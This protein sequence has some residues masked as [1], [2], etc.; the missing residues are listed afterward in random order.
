MERR[1]RDSNPEVLADAGFRDRCIAVLPP[2]RG[3]LLFSGRITRWEAESTARSG[4][5]LPNLGGYGRGGIR[6]RAAW[7]AR[8]LCGNSAKAP[9]RIPPADSFMPTNGRGGI[10]THVTLVMSTHF[11]GVRLQPLGHP[12]RISGGAGIRSRAAWAA[13][14]L[15][16]NA[17]KA[18]GENPSFHHALSVFSGG[19]GIRRRAASAARPFCS[20]AAKVPVRIPSSTFQSALSGGAGIRTL[21]GLLDP[22]P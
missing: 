13:R 5:L 2:L 7:A 16:G 8:A 22:T 10:R 17:A 20:P 12:S 6:S 14:A 11:P 3:V 9:V 18:P 15:C 21:V 4:P 19:A 1:G